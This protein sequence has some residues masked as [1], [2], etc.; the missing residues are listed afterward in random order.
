MLNKRKIGI[1]TVT[2]GFHYHVQTPP[3]PPPVQFFTGDFTLQRKMVG[4]VMIPTLIILF[5]IPEISL[6]DI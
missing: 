4:R 1:N 5:Q 6:A 3:P 2:W